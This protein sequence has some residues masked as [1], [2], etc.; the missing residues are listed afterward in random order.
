MLV[1]K[2]NE[3]LDKVIAGLGF[4]LVDMEISPTR[5]IVVYIDKL[6]GVTIDDC[7]TVSNHLSNLFLVEEIDYNR[8]EVSS[9]GLERPLKKLSDFTRFVGS[10]VKLKTSELINGNKVFK[11]T[12][13]E[14]NGT[15]IHLELELGLVQV[16]EF[17]NI[18]KA[19]LVFELQKNTN[20]KT[21]NKKQ[22]IY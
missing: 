6:G 12:I 7:E 3:I 1:N 5:T 19:R 2:L 16:I 10:L 21:K 15:N 11:G 17:N 14:V 8:L 20:K 18:I 4:E 22:I 13:C 9:P